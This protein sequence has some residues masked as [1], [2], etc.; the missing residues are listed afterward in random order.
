MKEGDSSVAQARGARP[1]ETEDSVFSLQSYTYSAIMC[2]YSF[3]DKLTAVQYSCFF[4]SVKVE[5][6]RVLL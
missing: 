2:N 3:V 6:C 4:N 5:V 1:A